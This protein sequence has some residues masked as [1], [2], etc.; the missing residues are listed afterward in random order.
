M[1]VRAYSSALSSSAGCVHTPK[2]A[3]AAATFFAVCS[4]ARGAGPLRQPGLNLV[5]ERPRRGRMTSADELVLEKEHHEHHAR[6][7]QLPRRC[8]TVPAFRQYAQQ[9]PKQFAA[10]RKR[11]KPPELL[12]QAERRE[13][14]GGHGAGAHEAGVRGRSLEPH[15][16]CHER[17]LRE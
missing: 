3:E 15:S 2:S 1:C 6:H 7:G 17:S 13:D 12:V 9:R 11:V 4:T 5:V 8:P 10:T 14:A 16:G